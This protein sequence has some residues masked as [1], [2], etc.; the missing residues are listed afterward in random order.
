MV[1]GPDKQARQCADQRCHGKTQLPRH[2]AGDAMTRRAQAVDGPWR[3][4]L[5]YSVRSKNNHSSTIRPATPKM[6]SAWPVSNYLRAQTQ[7]HVPKRGGRKPSTKQQSKPV[8]AKCT[9]TE[10]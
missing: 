6:M 1:V 2:V 9:P 7:A 4:A 8:M 5:P 10:R 3:R